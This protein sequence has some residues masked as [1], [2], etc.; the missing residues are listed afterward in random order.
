MSFTKLVLLIAA[1]IFTVYPLPAVN[2]SQIH[3]FAQYYRQNHLR[4]AMYIIL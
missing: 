4:V 1:N 2:L 3:I